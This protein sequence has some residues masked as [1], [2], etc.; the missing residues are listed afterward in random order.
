MQNRHL[1]V[2]M[3]SNIRQTVLDQP[4]EIWAAGAVIFQR[5]EVRFSLDHLTGGRYSRLSRSSTG[6][7]QGS[8]PH[9]AFSAAFAIALT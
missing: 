7:V 3:E 1:R 9:M 8:L 4:D 5:V 2:I 6:P